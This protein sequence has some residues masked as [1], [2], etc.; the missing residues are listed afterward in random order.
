MQHAQQ[1]QQQK[2]QQQQRP[3]QHTSTLSP[4]YDNSHNF[5]YNYSTTHQSQQPPLSSS[6]THRHY[7]TTHNSPPHHSTTT[8]TT[9]T[10]GQSPPHTKT[11]SPLYPSSYQSHIS[12]QP[13]GGTTHSKDDYKLSLNSATG[14]KLPGGPTK[15][16]HAATTG[17]Y[18]GRHAPPA[19]AS[20]DL[21]FELEQIQNAKNLKR[22][23][24]DTKRKKLITSSQLSSL[25]NRELEA[26]K[27]K[28][29]LERE[30]IIKSYGGKSPSFIIESDALRKDLEN[31]SNRNSALQASLEVISAHLQTELYQLQYQLKIEN[32]I[33]QQTHE[34]NIE[35]ERRVRELR[36]EKLELETELKTEQDKLI[37]MNSISSGGG[38]MGGMLSI[39]NPM[40]NNKTGDKF[41]EYPPESTVIQNLL[42]AQ[43]EF[44]FSDYNLKRDKRL[45]SDVVKPPKK[46]FLKLEEV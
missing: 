17:F 37:N 16:Q 34:H 40:D 45:L 41:K 11:T 14:D 44:Y 4:I 35:L 6:S 27:K 29:N 18:V 33:S 31:M 24:L 7:S 2:Q 5:S 15:L 10:H 32:E 20:S 39:R 13:G 23:E 22:I 28:W 46:G 30:E 42:Q 12:K 8:T 25:A 1:Q 21:R 26:T 36:I 38:N 43:V 3:S 19:P 9:T